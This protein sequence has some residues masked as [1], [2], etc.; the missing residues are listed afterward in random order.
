LIDSLSEN[1]HSDL[2]KALPKE[3]LDGLAKSL[4]RAKGGKVSLQ[5]V[6]SQITD[7]EHGKLFD[8]SIL[9]RKTNLVD[10]L[11]DLKWSLSEGPSGVG[12]SRFGMLLAGSASMEWAKQYPSNNFTSPSVIHWHGSAPEQT[13]GLFYGQ[14]RYLIDNIK[15]IRRA[16]LESKGKYDPYTHDAEIASL[17]WHDLS[18]DEKKLVPPVILVGERDDLNEAGWSSLNKLLAEKYPVKVFLFDHNATS[19]NDPVANLTQ[20]ISGLFSSIALKNAFVFQGGMGNVDHLYN[21]LLNG[22]DKTTPALFNLY[23]TKLDNHTS[24]QINWTPYASLAL[25]SR[26]FPALCYDPELNSNFLNG[27]VDLDGN[28]NYKDEWVEEEISVS[29]DEIIV[30]KITWADWAFTQSIW[31]SEFDLVNAADTNIMVPDYLQIEVNSR[32]G[33]TPVIMRTGEQGLKYYQVSEA[34]IDMTAAVLSNWQTWQ[35]LAGLLT[36]FPT[37]LKQEVTKELST[38]YEADVAALKE[39]YEKQLKEKEAAFTEKI[40]LQIKNKLVELSSLAKN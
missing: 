20:T 10:D 21:G 34:V 24:D 3:N 37:K 29:G 6:I 19:K 11:K 7:N 23:A 33:K 26:A 15:L 13:L 5:E 14:L 38:K 12:R 1:I 36:Q 31:E 2:S 39:D 40:R 25:T 30:Y 27:A 4:K 18:E 22:L 17:T 28:K 9:G 35:E 32:K 16:E 8:A